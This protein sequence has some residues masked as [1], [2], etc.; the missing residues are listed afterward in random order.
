MCSEIKPGNMTFICNDVQL[1]LILGNILIYTIYNRLYILCMLYITL[2]MQNHI[3]FCYKFKVVFL[4][5]R[6]KWYSEF[7][8]FEYFL[9]KLLVEIATGK[10]ALWGIF[11]I[12]KITNT[13]N[14]I[15]VTV[16]QLKCNLILLIFSVSIGFSEHF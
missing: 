7:Y 11:Q 15:W 13:L 16:R 5:H 4:S 3:L 6:L 1:Y 10:I 9:R 2:L 14:M 8:S 12:L